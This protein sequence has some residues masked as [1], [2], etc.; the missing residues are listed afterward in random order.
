MLDRVAEAM[1]RPDARVAAVGEHKLAR[2]TDPDHLVVEQIRRHPDQ[3]ELASA[4]A[5][6]LVAC[7]EWDQVSEALE[8]DAVAVVNELG[9]RVVE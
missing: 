5:K 7:G 4:L 8:R 3:L 1:Q 2:R 6:Q 9:D